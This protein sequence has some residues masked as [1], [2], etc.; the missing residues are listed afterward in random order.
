MPETPEPIQTRKSRHRSTDEI[1]MGRSPLYGTL[2]KQQ[3]DI[4]QHKSDHPQCR[5]AP[6]GPGRGEGRAFLSPR[7]NKKARSPRTPGT[8]RSACQKVVAKRNRPEKW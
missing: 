3:P 4:A 7:S 2:I 5:R 8:W 1:R 6:D